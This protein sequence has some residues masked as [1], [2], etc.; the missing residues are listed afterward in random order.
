MGTRSTLFSMSRATSS[1]TKRISPG[2]TTALT[3]GF[4]L[5]P[6]QTPRRTA[7]QDHNPCAGCLIVDGGEAWSGQAGPIRP[8][9]VLKEVRPPRS[10]VDTLR[11]GDFFAPVAFPSCAI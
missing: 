8:F 10:G 4:L 2:A 6:G 3:P 1:P 11:G 7:P 9:D 5:I